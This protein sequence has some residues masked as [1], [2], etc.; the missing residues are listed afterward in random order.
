MTT[1]PAM[2]RMEPGEAGPRAA[3]R[4][5]VAEDDADCRL[6]LAVLLRDLGYEV[7]M[8]R[9]GAEALAWFRSFGHVALLVTDL[10]MPRV[11]GL[12]LSR[13]LL[14]L[15]PE[16]PVVAVTGAGSDR[17]REFETLAGRHV[18]LLPKPFDRAELRRAVERVVG[19]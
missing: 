9:D 7:T 19:E 2:Q 16:L 4:A 18:T 11:D 8:A 17:A 13:R 3:P 6:G 10:A 12:A 1:Q 15:D 14:A 5:I